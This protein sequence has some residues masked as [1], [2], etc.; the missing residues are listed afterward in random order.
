MEILD[1]KNKVSRV[2]DEGG[3]LSYERLKGGREEAS[4][5]IGWG[6]YRTDDRPKGDVFLMDLWKAYRQCDKIPNL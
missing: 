1:E 5:F 3:S 2:F 4:K 6:F